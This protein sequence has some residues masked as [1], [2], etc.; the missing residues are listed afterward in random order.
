MGIAESLQKYRQTSKQFVDELSNTFMAAVPT[1]KNLDILIDAMSASTCHAGYFATVASKVG[2]SDVV[3]ETRAAFMMC[4]CQWVHQVVVDSL[5]TKELVGAVQVM[6]HQI[7]TAR[8]KA[9][10][11]KSPM[12]DNV[13]SLAAGFFEHIWPTAGL[14]LVTCQTAPPIGCDAMRR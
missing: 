12:Y 9:N 7:P 5:S 4:I 8:L 11:A 2:A 6:Q 3:D 13:V 14:A 1:T 10:K